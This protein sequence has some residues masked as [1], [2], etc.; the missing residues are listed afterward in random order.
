MG[1][2]RR[3]LIA[4]FMV[5]T[6][7]QGTACN[8]ESSEST[9]DQPD[10]ASEPGSDSKTGSAKQAEPHGPAI[11]FN[12]ER[13]GMVMLNEDGFQKVAGIQSLDIYDPPLK[14]PGSGFYTYAQKMLRFDGTITDLGSAR[15][16]KVS[17]PHQLTR[18]GKLVA[19][20]TT[21]VGIHDGEA[22]Q[23]WVVTEQLS[24]VEISNGS[25]KDAALA[26]DGT[27]YASLPTHLAVRSPSGEW[28]AY[29]TP[30]VGKFG[31]NLAVGA[32]GILLISLR[33]KEFRGPNGVFRFSDG[34]F[35]KLGSKQLVE[36]FIELDGV[37]HAL[38]IGGGRLVRFVEGKLETVYAHRG[39]GKLSHLTLGADG[40]L[41]AMLADPRQVLRFDQ[42]E[43]TRLPSKSGELRFSLST[44]VDSFD[45]DAA[46]RVWLRSR[47]G[48]HLIDGDT[49]TDLLPGPGHPLPSLVKRVVVSGPG[50]SKLP[51]LESSGLIT[52]TGTVVGKD[53]EPAAGVP[54]EVCALYV[55]QDTA[56]STPTFR[57]KTPC[58]TSN[59]PFGQTE[60]DAEGRF[61]VANTP[62]LGTITVVYKDGK[63]WTQFLEKGGLK[64]CYDTPDEGTCDVGTIRLRR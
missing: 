22:W 17:R 3:L 34:T 61:S 35:T 53:G 52:R 55:A 25:V 26:P 8:R 47:F 54:I 27:L 45:V 50:P 19:T 58:A 40:K 4:S 15:E 6:C 14:A 43:V 60:T 29:E 12:L 2:I 16:T 64:S 11:Y 48:V 7:L 57:G 56:Y 37:V 21:T 5:A 51:A 44:T 30:I 46:G 36:P 10:P 23:T 39:T 9:G 28:Q 49:V 33:N 31:G 24:G 62:R 13:G 32:D 1:R 41:Y 38:E 63:T 59:D 18:D 42:G 20:G